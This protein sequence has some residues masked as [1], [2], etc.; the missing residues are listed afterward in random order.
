MNSTARRNDYKD[1]RPGGPDYTFKFLILG[2]ASVG[3]TTL[4]EKYIT[5][6][7]NPN[8]QVTVGV[9]FHVKNLVVPDSTGSPKTVKLQIWDMGGEERFRFL[10]PTYCLGAQGALFLYDT[11]NAR[12]LSSVTSWTHIVYHYTGR[13]PIL[14]VGTKID[15]K[16]G[17][18]ISTEAGIE[19]ARRHQLAGFVEVSSK[20]GINVEEAFETVVKLMMK[21]V[22]PTK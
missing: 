3:K 1:T 15:L 9:E 18:V 19:V 16:H 4:C 10:L 2:D 12:S 7:W 20:L 21:N 17:R 5:G 14:L 22:A 8:T 6:I 13:I 11:T